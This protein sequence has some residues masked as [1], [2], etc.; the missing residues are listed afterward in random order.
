MYLFAF[1]STEG[2][3]P[4]LTHYLSPVDLPMSLQNN[5]LKEYKDHWISD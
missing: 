4:G 5:I 2:E 1:Y 3:L